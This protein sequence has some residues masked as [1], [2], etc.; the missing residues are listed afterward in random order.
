MRLFDRLRGR[1]NKE[2]QPPIEKVAQET[3]NN[4][5]NTLGDRFAAQMK[6]REQ[7]AAQTAEVL[8]DIEN[9]VQEAR[10]RQRN[11]YSS[12]IAAKEARRLLEEIE[13]RKTAEELLEE[14]LE[15]LKR[16]GYPQR[17]I[18]IQ[19]KRYKK[20][21]EDCRGKKDSENSLKSTIN[22]TLS[23][24]D[25][26]NLLEQNKPMWENMDLLETYLEKLLEQ[27][28]PIEAVNTIRNEQTMSMETLMKSGMSYEDIRRTLENNVGQYVNDKQ[29][30]E[31]EIKDIS[32]GIDTPEKLLEIY[33]K[34]LQEQ[35]VPDRTIN[36]LRESEKSSLT[37]AR[38]SSTVEIIKNSI[39]KRDIRKK[40]E[41][42]HDPQIYTES[43]ENYLNACLARLQEKGIAAEQIK[44]YRNKIS[45]HLETLKSQSKRPNYVLN[46]AIVDDLNG[47]IAADTL[48]D[49]YAEQ[50][51]VSGPHR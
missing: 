43:P 48:T 15:K 40:F 12:Q 21:L 41:K 8:R 25:D 28:F 30:I 20:F 26:P 34:R 4:L 44:E 2:T 36:D 46:R 45:K 5:P 31:Q 14:K 49:G 24:V 17:V 13:K 50:P 7:E 1:N 42:Y 3:I 22:K 16:A 23:W 29:L 38:E 33:L 32:E 37:L 18:D 10:K 27:G 35:G 51:V 19:R 9:G 39:L 47:L 11:S 6:E